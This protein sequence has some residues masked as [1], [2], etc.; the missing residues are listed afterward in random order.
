MPISPRTFWN[1]GGSVGWKLGRLLG[2]ESIRVEATESPL[3]GEG[4]ERCARAR[5]AS[6]RM[7]EA[8]HA[9]GHDVRGPSLELTLLRGETLSSEVA[10][11]RPPGAGR[12]TRLHARDVQQADTSSLSPHEA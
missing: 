1:V 5:R 9:L 7:S 6:R 3:S 2:L 4:R 8:G 11:Q 10:E 12:F